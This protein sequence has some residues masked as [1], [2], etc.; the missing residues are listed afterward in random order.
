MGQRAAGACSHPTHLKD[1]GSRY[2]TGQR[3]GQCGSKA[4]SIDEWPKAG[5]QLN[6]L[7]RILQSI[8]ADPNVRCGK[9][10]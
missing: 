4:A 5:Y 8:E 1:L 7:E 3:R 6:Y 2:Q 10:N 9:L